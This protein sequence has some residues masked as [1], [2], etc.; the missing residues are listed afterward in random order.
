MKF[1]DDDD[2]DDDD[3][4]EHITASIPPILAECFLLALSMVE[5]LVFHS[6]SSDEGIKPA[7]CSDWLMLSGVQ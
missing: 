1:V 7:S 5:Q 4:T 3:V 2:D 6:S